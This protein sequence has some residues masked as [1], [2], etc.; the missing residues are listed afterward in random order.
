MSNGY[1][2]I[3]QEFAD[4]QLELFQHKMMLFFNERFFDS[5]LYNL[6]EIISSYAESMNEFKELFF[7]YLEEKISSWLLG[8]ILESKSNF[9]IRKIIFTIKSYTI[10]LTYK[11]YSKEKVISI[12]NIVIRT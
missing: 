8:Q 7:L 9:E 6:E 2:I 5:W 12:E 11:Q 1:T 3:I 4:Y 10:T